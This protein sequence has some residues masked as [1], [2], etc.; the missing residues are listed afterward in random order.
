MEYGVLLMAMLA[1]PLMDVKDTGK[2]HVWN[3]WMPKSRIV[4][5]LLVE[6]FSPR[7]LSHG[8]RYCYINSTNDLRLLVS[9]AFWI[10]KNQWEDK[11]VQKK[12]QYTGLIY[13]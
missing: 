1:R 8:S 9:M 7:Q 2:V 13:V 12:Q 3:R 11:S 6:R 5:I 10:K 4:L